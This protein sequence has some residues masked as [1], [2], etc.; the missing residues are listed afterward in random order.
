MSALFSQSP[1][2]DIR[3]SIRPLPLTTL[4]PDC[5]QRVEMGDWEVDENG[6]AGGIQNQG[7]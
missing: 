5:A 1:L 6:V 3:P 7:C 4:A 2:L